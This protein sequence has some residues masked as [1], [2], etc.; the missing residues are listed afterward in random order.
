MKGIAIDF[1]LYAHI[2]LT[3]PWDANETEFYLQG[4]A[5]YRHC[6]MGY[7]SESMEFWQGSWHKKVHEKP[8]WMG[9]SSDGHGEFSFNTADEMLC[10]PVFDGQSLQSFWHQIRFLSIGGMDAAEWL[11]MQKKK[12]EKEDEF[13]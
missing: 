2:L 6:W 5:K 11:E 7:L 12:D 3:Q 8:Y 1:S 13:G 9:L 4:N 10:A